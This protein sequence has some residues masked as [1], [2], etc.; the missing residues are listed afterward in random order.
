MEVGGSESAANCNTALAAAI[1]WHLHTARYGFV[2]SPLVPRGHFSSW[3][4]ICQMLLS[5][6]KACRAVQRTRV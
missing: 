5:G 6:T 4:G 1:L 2:S 3:R